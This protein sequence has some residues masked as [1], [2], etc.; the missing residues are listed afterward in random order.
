MKIIALFLALLMLFG[1]S[2]SEQVMNE[3]PET[4]P[5]EEISVPVQK[6]PE[7]KKPTKIEYIAPLSKTP[8][9]AVI[10]YF[11]ALYDSYIEMLPVDISP[12]IDKDFEMMEN[13]LNWNNLLAMRRSIISENDY[14]YV[15]T[16]RF[17]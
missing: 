1:C 16:E 10:N 8:E 7:V 15:E 6:E 4:V 9:I 17:P 14:C 13:V 5:E 12:V 2:S 3:I 11:D